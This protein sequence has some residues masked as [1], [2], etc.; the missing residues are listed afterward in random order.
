M[1]KCRLSSAVSLMLKLPP[2]S[3]LWLFRA[4]YHYQGSH[5][6]CFVPLVAMVSVLTVTMALSYTDMNSGSIDRTAAVRD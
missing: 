2:T 4:C 3:F 1:M 6:A 5:G